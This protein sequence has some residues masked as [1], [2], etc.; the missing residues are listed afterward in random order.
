[1]TPE[2]S[3]MQVISDRLKRVERQN[4]MAKRT[5]LVILLITGAAVAMGQAPAKRTVIADEFVLKDS[6]GIV[7]AT[8]GFVRNEP[9]LTLIDANT[10]DRAIL[11]TEA[12]DFADSN[13][14]TRVVLGS[15]SAIY[16]KLAEGRTQVVDQGPGLLFS[17]ADGEP[18]TEEE[19]A[20]FATAAGTAQQL[21]NWETVRERYEHLLQ[22]IPVRWKEYVNRKKHFIASFVPKGKPG[23]PPDRETLNQILE[24]QSQGKSLRE[25]AVIL[26][27]HPNQIP[28]AVDR[29][30]KL[31]ASARK[32]SKRGTNPA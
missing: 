3:E 21:F 25:I 28:S 19:L 26:G 24:L 9:T 23:R 22:R 10:R 11:T 18:L 31:I 2:T 17:G 29:Y 27:A 12:M 6:A 5:A 20:E 30:H 13:G 8:L 14:L 1:M 32:R 7:R 15:S 16:Y 4:R